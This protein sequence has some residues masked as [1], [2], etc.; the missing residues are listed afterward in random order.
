MPGF[1]L[2]T[3]HSFSLCTS[4]LRTSSCVPKPFLKGRQHVLPYICLECRASKWKLMDRGDRCLP[5]SDKQD[6]LQPHRRVSWGRL[7]LGSDGT[8]AVLDTLP[9]PA[10]PPTTDEPDQD[11]HM[12]RV[13]RREQA[14]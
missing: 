12:A 13:N 4:G 11:S 2:P 10:A 7:A 3:P 1:P 8:L 14:V 5:Y 6:Q 9:T